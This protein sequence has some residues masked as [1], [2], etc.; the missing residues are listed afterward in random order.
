MGFDLGKSLG[1]GSGGGALIGGAAGAYFGGP[2]AGL[3]GAQL[4][5]ALDA[6]EETNSK[7][8][9]KWHSKNECHQQRTSAK[10]Q[11]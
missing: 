1:I 3:L 8:Q 10:S 5:R 4:G 11:T 6:N 9:N 7:H 2:M